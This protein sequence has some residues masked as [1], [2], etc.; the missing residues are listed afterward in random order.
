VSPNIG[1]KIYFLPEVKKNYLPRCYFIKFCVFLSRP[2]SEL[3]A[4]DFDCDDNYSSK[5]YHRGDVPYLAAECFGMSGGDCFS[6]Y[7]DCPVS[8]L[9]FISSMT[10]NQTIL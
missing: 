7:A 10:D 4:A 6:R 1:N 9:D 8:P 5:K 3:S 2:S